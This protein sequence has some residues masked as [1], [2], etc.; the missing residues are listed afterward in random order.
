MA[1]E[2]VFL[3]G[4][5]LFGG[6]FLS[7]SI[8]HFRH[9]TMMTQYSASKHVPVPGLAVAGSGVMLLLGGL[10]VILCAWPTAG[11]VLIILFLFGV[12]PVMHNYWAV[13]DPNQRMND[14]INF[15]KN[16]ALLGA[17]LM[18]LMI[19]QPWALSVIR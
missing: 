15:F 1:M 14:Q 19:P 5:I 6:F 4:R 7:S 2:I 16:F 10:C 12:T 13:T 3:I 18:M 17:A 11:L 9:R 8:N